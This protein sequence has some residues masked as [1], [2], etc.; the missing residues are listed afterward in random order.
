M[1]NGGS[2]N[3]FTRYTRNLPAVVRS[4]RSSGRGLRE[5]L[6]ERS[7][8]R[9]RSPLAPAGR[10]QSRERDLTSADNIYA[11]HRTLTGYPTLPANLCPLS[12][13]AKFARFADN[14]GEPVG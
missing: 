14:L 10:W 13:G 7:S 4:V 6:A 2:H 5:I 9:E 12:G 8:A 1:S 3:K 11:A